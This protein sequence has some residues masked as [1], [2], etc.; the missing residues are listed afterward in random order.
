MPD[1]TDA[2]TKRVLI[3]DDDKNMV[4]RLVEFFEKFNKGELKLSDEVTWFSRWRFET[5]FA[6]DEEGIS[7]ALKGLPL[8][9]VIVIDRE[10]AARR[11]LNLEIL[12][13][14]KDLNQDCV[15]IIWTAHPELED[16]P[17]FSEV[18]NCMRLDAWDFID[19]SETQYDNTF[20]DVVVSAI[21]GLEEKEAL[22][23]KER[24]DREAHEFVVKHYGQI[25]SEHKGNFMAYERDGQDWKL[26][27]KNESL[28]GLYMEL[29][30][31]GKDRKKLHITLI[32]E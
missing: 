25:Y 29:E 14:L 19:K 24:L 3:L 27:A 23:A 9:D 28:F 5:N 17:H 8:V 1:E 2:I 6:A 13:T 4:K 30:S 21:K 32:H 20:I 22:V 12:Q 7:T 15:R 10:F 11:C 18:I 16:K 26:V 31:R